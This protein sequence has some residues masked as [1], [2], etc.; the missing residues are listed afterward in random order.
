M[1]FS[2]KES[3]PD[4]LKTGLG[5]VGSIGSLKSPDATAAFAL[6]ELILACVALNGPASPPPLLPAARMTRRRGFGNRPGASI[7]HSYRR[8]FPSDSGRRCRDITIV[9]AYHKMLTEGRRREAA[10]NLGYFS[11]PHVNGLL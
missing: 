11:I 5:R 4:A 7:S 1:V 8:D 9:A 2:A 3:L 10:V 6:E